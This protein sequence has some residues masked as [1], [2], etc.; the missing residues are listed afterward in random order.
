M[1]HITVVDVTIKDL[2]SLEQACNKLGLNF[3][4]FKKKFKWYGHK[5]GDCEHAIGVPDNSMA[6]EIGVCFQDTEEGTYCF[7]WDNYRGGMGLQA[8][9]GPGC[10]YLINEYTKEV[11]RKEVQDMALND[12]WMYDEEVNDNTGETTIT[13]RKY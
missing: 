8:L 4:K 11:V 2:E 1:S 9:V 12:G 5:D 7:K 6:Y 13:L 3:Q 10:Q